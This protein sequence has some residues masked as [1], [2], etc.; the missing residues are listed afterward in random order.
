[1]D[2]LSTA[3]AVLKTQRQRLV[4]SGTADRVTEILREQIIGGLLP[5]GTR[6]SEETIGEALGVSRNTLR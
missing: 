5:P 4:R 2:S 1:M 6:L 3:S